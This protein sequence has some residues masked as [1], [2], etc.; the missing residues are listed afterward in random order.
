M[1]FGLTRKQQA[2]V[3][4]VRKFARKE[5]KP[6]AAENDR[7]GHFPE[8]EIRSA[9]KI[10]LTGMLVP[11]EYGGS[12]VGPVAYCLVLEEV[13][14]CCA[15]AAVTLSVTNMVAESLYKWGSEEQ[16]RRLLPALFGGRY[17]TGGFALT[18]S[19]A[20]SDATALSTRAE[21]KGDR[22]ILNGSKVFITSG[23]VSSFLIVYAKTDPKRRS[24]GITAFVVER[25]TP[26][27]IIGKHEDKM[28]LRASRTVQLAFEDCEVPAEN[29][30]G[31]EG[32][33]FKVAM[34][35]LDGGRIGIASQALGIGRAALEES[36]RYASEREQ[37]GR[38]LNRIQAVQ[39]MLADMATELDGARLMVMRAASVKAAGGPYTRE[40]AMAK[41]FATEAANRACVKAVQIHGGYG[42]TADYPVE[43]LM[44]DCKVTTLYEGT[45]EVQRI[46]IARHTLG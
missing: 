40:A 43:R 35:A 17:P 13:A 27:L 9:A 19:H 7:T 6:V 36:L 45:S 2:I 18:E 1:E 12:D 8:E 15:S 41:V 4:S 26:G 33:G 3:A 24:R 21:R 42:Y 10:G 30:L 5:L 22:Y 16:R 23:D 39:L 11:S 32:E 14:T 44:R 38:S 46:V 34:S 37:F 31:E 28:G 20:G 29:R 25:D